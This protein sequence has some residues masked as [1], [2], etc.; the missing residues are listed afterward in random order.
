MKVLDIQFLN[1]C[2]N[3][4]LNIGGKVCHFL[5]LSGS[6]NQTGKSFETL[7]D[8]LELDI[9]TLTNINLF[10]IVAIGNFNAK[11]INRYKNDTTFYKGTKIDAILSQFGL[12]K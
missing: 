5:C 6:P 8:N 12:N 10:L 1:E 11:T 7:A 9:D 3:F 2:L 4:E